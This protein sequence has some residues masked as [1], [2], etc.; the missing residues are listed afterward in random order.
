MNNRIITI[1]KMIKLLFEA[2]TEIIRCLGHYSHSV[3]EVE[4]KYIYHSDLSGRQKK[5]QDIAGHLLSTSSNTLWKRH[6]EAM[7]NNYLRINSYSLMKFLVKLNNILNP[8]KG[9]R[10]PKKSMQATIQT[11]I[12]KLIEILFVLYSVDDKKTQQ[13]FV[14]L[15]HSCFDFEYAKTIFLDKNV[16]LLDYNFE[17]LITFIL[18][19]S[20]LQQG[21]KNQKDDLNKLFFI[22][23]G[24]SEKA[25]EI[26][27]LPHFIQAVEV[28]NQA[29]YLE[30][31]KQ[32][33]NP[34]LLTIIH[35]AKAI[36]SLLRE[37]KKLKLTMIDVILLL[38]ALDR[39][40]MTPRDYHLPLINWTYKNKALASLIIDKF[41]PTLKPSQAMTL[42]RIHY[43]N[44]SREMIDEK[45]L[46]TYLENNL[47]LINV[48][49]EDVDLR[50][51]L[52]KHPL[53]THIKK[54]YHKL[55]P[56]EHITDNTPQ[57]HVMIEMARFFYKFFH[58]SPSPEIKPTEPDHKDGI[59]PKTARF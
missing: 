45:K 4:A 27:L 48:M 34:K 49:Y 14:E 16:D 29:Y 15:I 2:R 50:N 44:P 6:E 11:V 36:D 23:F 22:I 57:P 53:G 1:Q 7:L 24:L 58:P 13:R 26:G 12:K 40:Q 43:E 19:Q 17:M 54:I 5:L 28:I 21:N 31:K 33:I 32:I 30:H 39:F 59:F 52:S 18:I 56:Y 47:N 41:M 8:I 51:I 10:P 46:F 37:K 25:H 3:S 42:L 9:H 38:Q 55:N 20:K 35:D